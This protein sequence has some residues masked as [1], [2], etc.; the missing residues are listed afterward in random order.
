[1][2]LFVPL[3]F[4]HC[5][6][7]DG[8]FS[9]IWGGYLICDHKPARSIFRR[10]QE[11]GRLQISVG[12]DNIEPPTVRFI[13]TYALS[14]PYC[15]DWGILTPLHLTEWYFSVIIFLIIL[16]RIAYKMHS[17][18]WDLSSASQESDSW[19]LCAVVSVPWSNS[20]L[21]D[22]WIANAFLG[23]WNTLPRASEVLR[24]LDSQPLLASPSKL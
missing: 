23:S 22:P 17:S 7:L 4:I 19:T 10:V 9:F 14:L 3:P 16:R 8:C 18:L 5:Y 20:V 6:V 2:P 15:T 13:T 1:M 11:E 24:N 12:V 21:H